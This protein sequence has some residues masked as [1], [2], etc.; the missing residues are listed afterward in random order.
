M[1]SLQEGLEEMLAATIAMLGADRG[2]MQLLDD[3]RGALRIMAQR[4]FTQDFL[5]GFRDVS[6]QDDSTCGRA[7]RLASASWSKTS[8]PMRRSLRCGR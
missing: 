8:R 4:G 7:L 2:T 5:D 3:T 6:A 1:Q